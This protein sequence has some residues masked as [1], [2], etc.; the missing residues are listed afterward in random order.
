MEYLVTF[1]SMTHKR[2]GAA[3]AGRELDGD[4]TQEIFKYIQFK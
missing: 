4:M 1:L 2:L 3:S